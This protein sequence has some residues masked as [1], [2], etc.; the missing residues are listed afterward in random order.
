MQAQ[1]TSVAE[2]HVGST[3]LVQ[4]GTTLTVEDVEEFDADGG[5]LSVGGEVRSYVVVDDELIISAALGGVYAE[6]DEVL[7]YPLQV[8]RVAYVLEA[9]AEEELP[10]RVPHSLHDRLALGTRDEDGEM[11]EVEGAGEE[12]VVR[13]VLAL[14]PGN[15]AGYIANVRLNGGTVDVDVTQDPSVLSGPVEHG[16]GVEPSTVQ[17][18]VEDG[19]GKGRARVNHAVREVNDL[20]F[21]IKLGRDDGSNLTAPVG[22]PFVRVHWFAGY[23]GVVMGE[24]ASEEQAGITGH[25]ETSAPE[26]DT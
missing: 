19:P 23:F 18:T 16:L 25:V 4:D 8:E 20:T 21:R 14:E 24:P 6:G 3:L 17:L 15:D 13:D 7:V 11:V 9:G 22:S 26:M 5:Q 2:E 1:V 12:L 10:A